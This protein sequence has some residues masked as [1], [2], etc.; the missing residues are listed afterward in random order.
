MLYR[1]TIIAEA[2]IPVGVG[3]LNGELGRMLAYLMQRCVDRQITGALV[4]DSGH[5]L[6]VFE[7]EAESLDHIRS[8]F[9][10][11]G[12]HSNM[13]VVEYAPIPRRDYHTW[14]VGSQSPESQPSQLIKKFQTIVP[15]AGEV[16]RQV[17]DL[18]ALGT[19]AETPPLVGP[20]RRARA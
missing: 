16:R 3:A 18:I 1:M 2:S 14:S 15:T 7:G 12:R 9:E 4:L 11:L 6:A 10:R 17:C 20:P 8:R 5:F 19:F 13:T